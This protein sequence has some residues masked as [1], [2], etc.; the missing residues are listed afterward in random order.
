[1]HIANLYCKLGTHVLT[2]ISSAHVYV[3]Y[4]CIYMF[5][6]LYVHTYNTCICVSRMFVYLVSMYTSVYMVRF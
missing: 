2:Y 6:H 3:F 1:M 5:A 4:V